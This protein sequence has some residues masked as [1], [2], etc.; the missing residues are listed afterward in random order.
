MVRV[1]D[2]LSSILTVRDGFKLKEMRRERVTRRRKEIRTALD[3][4]NRFR[5]IP[6]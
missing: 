3:W 2:T 5:I 4:P 6:Y 1:G